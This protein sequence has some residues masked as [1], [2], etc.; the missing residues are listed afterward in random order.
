MTNVTDVDCKIDDA[1]AAERERC[2]RIAESFFK[3]YGYD[4]G[5]MA[6]RIAEVIRR[7]PHN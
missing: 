5:K 7:Q 3:D 1:V 4:V 6:R 2:A